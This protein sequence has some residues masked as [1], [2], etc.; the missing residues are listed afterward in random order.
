MDSD[1]KYIMKKLNEV[2]EELKK[3]YEHNNKVVE[4]QREIAVLKQEVKDVTLQMEQRQKKYNVI[5][6][7]VITAVV[8]AFTWVLNKFM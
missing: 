7:S 8:S 1:L 4:L 5:V 3:M 6:G 2:S